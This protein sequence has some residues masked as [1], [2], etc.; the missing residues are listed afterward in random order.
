MYV[1]PTG[2]YWC[3][4]IIWLSLTCSWQCFFQRHYA[5]TAPADGMEW[6]GAADLR[7]ITKRIWVVFNQGQAHIFFFLPGGQT[8]FVLYFSY[9]LHG[10]VWGERVCLILEWHSTLFFFHFPRQ[11]SLFRNLS[12]FYFEVSHKSLYLKQKNS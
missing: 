2:F 4:I 11:Q 6:W 8:F 5:Q 9:C 7:A 10:K 1:T 3:D 12:S